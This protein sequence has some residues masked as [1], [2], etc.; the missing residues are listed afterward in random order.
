M[1]RRPSSPPIAPPT[2]AVEGAP[3]ARDF[4]VQLYDRCD[5]EGVNKRLVVDTLF[6][7]AFD[8]L[9]GLPVDQRQAVARRVHEGSYGRMVD[10]AAGDPVAS[11]TDPIGSVPAPSNTR[12]FKSTAPRPPKVGH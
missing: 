8:A 6:R 9:D 4:V 12:V 3:F 5:G 11:K 2:S 10:D 7:A 1:A